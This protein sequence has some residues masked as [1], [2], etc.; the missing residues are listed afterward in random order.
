MLTAGLP[1]KLLRVAAR[2]GLSRGTLLANRGVPLTLQGRMAP[3]A[4]TGRGV[5]AAALERLKALSASLASLRAA[6]DSQIA[7][8]TVAILAM[9]NARRD[10]GYA[11]RPSLQ[12]KGF[13]RVAMV[14]A[15]GAILS[16]VTKESGAELIPQGT[17]RIAVWASPSDPAATI[18]GLAGWHA[19]QSL[20]YIGWSTCLCA[21]GSVY[22][23]AAKMTRGPESFTTGWIAAKEFLAD[24][25]LVTTRFT[26]PAQT[27][28]IMLDEIAGEPADFSLSLRGAKIASDATGDEKSPILLSQGA[29][30]LLVYALMPGDTGFTVEIL[31]EGAVAVAGVMA[32]P[33]LAATTAA[34][35]TE[36]SAE[37]LLDPPLA[38]PGDGVTLRFVQG[39][40]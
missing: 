13:A 40:R 19:G 35:L 15:G 10:S 6:A 34:R 11:S 33:A 37:A 30:R 4:S 22:S 1:A 21:G 25:R 27:L 39:R 26:N 32:S 18:S 36:E 29:R 12:F 9:P 7:P 16:D 3:A 5:D 28:V 2:A 23:E 38:N 8:G 20:A 31:R 14:G 24:S 17:E